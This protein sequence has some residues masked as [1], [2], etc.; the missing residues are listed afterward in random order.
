MSIRAEV[1]LYVYECENLRLN[2]NINEVAIKK[3]MKKKIVSPKRVFE[4]NELKIT[5][6]LVNT[7]KPD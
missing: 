5:C 4:L 1:L 3:S 7:K 6:D 2:K